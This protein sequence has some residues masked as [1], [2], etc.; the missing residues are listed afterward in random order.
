MSM[1]QEN[2]VAPVE[3][4]QEGPYVRFVYMRPFKSSA[5]HGGAVCAATIVDESIP[6]KP[7]LKVG[8]TFC[9]PRDVFVKKIARCKASGRMLSAH[10]VTIP[11]SGNAYKDIVNYFNSCGDAITLNGP[12]NKPQY[13]PQFCK[14]WNIDLT[15]GEISGVQDKYFNR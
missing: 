6:E 12:D 3:L 5:N 8:F 7:Q 10:A 1:Y 13:K 15:T 2:T 9:S 11:F 14:H 4:P